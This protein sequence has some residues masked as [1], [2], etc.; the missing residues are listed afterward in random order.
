MRRLILL[1]HA[2]SDWHQDA[3]DHARPLNA[4]GR[5]EAPFLGDHLRGIGWLPQAVRVSDATRTRQTW[6][7]LAPRLA[8]DDMRLDAQL[9]LASAQ[10]ILT[11][12]GDLPDA[13]RCG[14]LIGHNPG[15]STAASYLAG[16][17]LGLKTATAALL[18]HPGDT[19]AAAT[20]STGWRLV[21][22]VRAR[23]LF[24]SMS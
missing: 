10:T 22:V 2:K 17:A 1:R 12:A 18:T 19:W 8:T 15:M 7:L 24:E 9:Y 4:R 11:V 21:D 20:D 16:Q 14:L 13:A 23:V 3:T 5:R 6:D